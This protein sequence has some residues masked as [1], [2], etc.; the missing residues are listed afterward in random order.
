VED[1]LGSAE[2]GE[3]LGAEEAVGVRDDADEHGVH[4]LA[5]VEW[6]VAGG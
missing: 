5:S 3:G 2:G 6:A 1:V 4:S